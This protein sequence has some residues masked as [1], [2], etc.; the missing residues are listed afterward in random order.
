M[1]IVLPYFTLC[2]NKVCCLYFVVL[3]IY[4]RYWV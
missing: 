1:K 4:A 3:F 2:V